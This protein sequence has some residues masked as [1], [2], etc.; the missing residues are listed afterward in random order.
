MR[1][2]PAGQ[3]L[4]AAVQG[5]IV[6]PL[7]PDAVAAAVEES[8]C[9]VNLDNPP[10]AAEWLDQLVRGCQNVE[11]ALQELDAGSPSGPG[12]AAAT[13]GPSGQRG[14]TH[15]LGNELARTLGDWVRPMIEGRA[16]VMHGVAEM[17]DQG[18]D[19]RIRLD[20]IAT[21]IVGSAIGS[22]RLQ[23]PPDASVLEA[24]WGLVWLCVHPPRPSQES[25]DAKRWARLQSPQKR[26]HSIDD[27]HS[28]RGFS[29]PA[30]I[31]W[32]ESLKL[33]DTRR[34]RR[35]PDELVPG[36][37]QNSNAGGR[38]SFN[39][40]IGSFFD[41]IAAR[42]INTRQIHSNRAELRW[43]F[44]ELLRH[45]GYTVREVLRN[46]TVFVFIT[47]PF[48]ILCEQAEFVKL[49]VPLRGEIWKL[50]NDAINPVITV[51]KNGEPS[52]PG[53]DT[54]TL[55][56]ITCSAMN[57]FPHDQT[58][59]VRRKGA[60]VELKYKRKAG[61]ITGEN[62]LHMFSE[63][64]RSFS[65]SRDVVMLANL[66][67]MLEWEA[68]FVLKWDGS[69]SLAA[70]TSALQSST[71]DA[72]LRFRARRTTEI[73]ITPVRISKSDATN[74]DQ[75]QRMIDSCSCAYMSS[76]NRPRHIADLLASF[77]NRLS[78]LP[79]ADRVK[80]SQLVCSLPHLV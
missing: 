37:T 19:P 77:Y 55:P 8:D 70:R 16:A 73:G 50:Q 67:E 48:S 25:S 17:A 75:T 10:P 20:A 21:A 61:R 36:P 69:S 49:N 24:A 76:N 13:A 44:H 56:T 79:E 5:L 35:M 65:S 68:D 51:S 54:I 7:F 30:L 27:S 80:V 66:H 6:E 31:E 22:F 3:L 59:P 32:L 34:F 78:E 11:K 60:L 23:D 39:R 12:G 45:K 47:A 40:L 9:E 71:T 52:N 74:D 14:A 28:N 29:M 62:A 1:T 33:A 57:T 72:Q 43:Y 42:D 4:G 63:V 18:S 58:R 41:S 64:V 46:G 53:H 15:W 2:A 38:F 26:D